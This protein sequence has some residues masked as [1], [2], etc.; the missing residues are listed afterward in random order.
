VYLAQP[1]ADRIVIDGVSGSP[2]PSKNVFAE[3]RDAR[4]ADTTP[5]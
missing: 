5:H 1:L 4:P 2:V 3:L